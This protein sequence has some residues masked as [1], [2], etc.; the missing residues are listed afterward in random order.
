MNKVTGEETRTVGFALL[1][2]Q[3]R[4]ASSPAAILQSLTR[5]RDRLEGEA[6][7]MRAA[8]P[9]LPCAGRE[10]QPASGG[11]RGRLAPTEQTAWE[12]EA[13]SVATT[14]RTLEELEVE[15]AI[16]ER[17][18]AK[19]ESVRAADVDAKWEALA[20]LLRSDEMYDDERRRRKIIIFTEHRDPWTTSRSG[21]DVSSARRSRS[22]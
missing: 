3:R 12:D 5:R 18:V 7:R 20:G 2:L 21:S 13:S 14:A 16:L 6:E 11:R 4:L 9:A 8:R 19:A 22:R 1:V 10:P 15:V 17:L